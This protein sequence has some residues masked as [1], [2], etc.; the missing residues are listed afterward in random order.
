MKW[1]RRAH[2]QDTV[3]GR[4]GGR[5]W[6]SPREFQRDTSHAVKRYAEGMN[7]EM[8]PP[9][10]ILQALHAIKGSVDGVKASVDQTKASVDQTNARLDQTNERLESLRTFT[11]QGLTDL[12]AKVDRLGVVVDRQGNEIHQLNERLDHFFVGEGARQVKRIDLLETEVR[13]IAQKVDH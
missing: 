4:G 9:N 8:P 12:N 2:A 6:G 3:H 7:D 13:R 11:V 10:L 1:L 5:G